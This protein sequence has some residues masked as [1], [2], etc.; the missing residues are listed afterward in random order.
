MHKPRSGMSKLGI[1]A[2]FGTRVWSHAGYLAAKYYHHV[3]ATFVTLVLLVSFSE[4]YDWRVALIPIVVYLLY[5]VARHSIPEQLENR[6][7]K[8]VPQLLRAEIGMVA[9]LL[10]LMVLRPKV[11]QLQKN[12]LPL[13][14]LFILALMLL[15]RHAPTWLFI[16]N[17]ALACL[18][19]LGVSAWNSE[20]SGVITPQF[21]FLDPV[22]AINCLSLVLIAFVVHYLVRN[23]EA[24]EY[25]IDSFQTID[26]LTDEINDVGELSEKWETVIAACLKILKA[27][28]SI[29]WM[30]DY[31]TQ[32]IRPLNQ[33]RM[34]QEENC[35]CWN[36]RCNLE[37]LLMSDDYP[38]ARVIRT[39]EPML[40]Q[41]VKKASS[42]RVRVNGEA[43]P[44]CELPICIY[45][46]LIVPI[47]ARQG[48]RQRPVGAF[49]LNFSRAN[50]PRSELLQDYYD[51]AARQAKLL[52]PLL[53]QLQ[54]LEE[55][56]ALQ[57]ID[58]QIVSH[59]GQKAVLQNVLDA[60]IKTLGFDFAVISYLGHETQCLQPAVSHNAAPEIL[61]AAACPLHSDRVAADAIIHSR[62]KIRS[63]RQI[64]F[65]EGRGQSQQDAT[66]VLTPIMV[67]GKNGPDHA[68]GVIEAGYY[69]RNGEYIK[70]EQLRMLCVLARKAYLAMQNARLFERMERRAESLASLHRISG[71]IASLENFEDVLDQVGNTL[72]AFLGADIIMVY[73]LD[74]HTKKLEHPPRIFGEIKGD[75]PLSL[76]SHERGIIAKVLN[77]GESIYVPN[78]EDEP[79]LFVTTSSEVP[80]ASDCRRRSFTQRQ[81]VVSFAG[82]P[83][84]VSQD[85]VGV[86]CVNYRQQHSFSKGERQML[87][88]AAQFAAVALYNAETVRLAEELADTQARI[89]LA[90]KLHHSIAQYLRAIRFMAETAEAHLGKD[91]QKVTYNLNQIELALDQIA[92]EL[93]A[94][95]FDLNAQHLPKIDLKQAL[96]EQV[97]DARVYFD[98]VVELHLDLESGPPLSA[99]L[100]QDLLMLCR[101]AIA[102]T[103]KHAS[104]R[105]VLLDL[106][107]RR[108]AVS[109]LIQDDGCGFVPEQVMG[110]R[111]GGLVMMRDHIKRL[112]GE[113][114]IDS[115]AGDG[116]TICA[117]IPIGPG[118]PSSSQ[119]RLQRFV[120]SFSRIFS[121]R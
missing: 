46:C 4:R 89:Q 32:Q 76:P 1:E 66:S 102:N 30:G 110:G 36:E 69:G 19:M 93:R 65:L 58:L 116:T 73:R 99:Q 100:C 96:E 111:R 113:F 13:W 119:S 12:Q 63:G 57:H 86:L 5:F 56:Q 70:P 108:D 38:I 61:K 10:V 104:A 60:V 15:S 29:V 83:M 7:Y 71:E 94:N 109:L 48:K 9:M 17:V 62:Q 42:D 87:E 97:R 117:K 54:Q 74:Q 98:L 120:A 105:C 14:P 34:C 50:S 27:K 114:E 115:N 49:S 95:V 80:D 79:L 53:Q 3:I 107:V 92:R 20:F 35:P 52:K 23:I 18:M 31:V 91:D 45:T 121:N 8:R 84:I 81:E 106:Q 11:D 88:I 103:A 40:C 77:S 64:V 6:F 16:V 78:V 90:D 43:V 33:Y 39:S 82:V 28:C 24:R 2:G 68:L 51:F 44:T 75:K 67:D 59:L 85:T 21:P 41:S 118:N 22:L 101:E 47:P 55:L 26:D 72:Q 112:N 25:I 37:P